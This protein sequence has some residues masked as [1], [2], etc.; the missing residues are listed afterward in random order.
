M[1]FDLHFLG[2]LHC[3]FISTLANFFGYHFGLRMENMLVEYMIN[4]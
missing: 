1:L 4:E 3:F 2:F